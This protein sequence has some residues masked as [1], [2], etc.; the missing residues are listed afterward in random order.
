MWTG[1]AIFSSNAPSHE[2][3]EAGVFLVSRVKPK[4][5]LFVTHALESVYGAATS[6]RL[7]LENYSGV[8]ADLLLPRSFR[9]PRDLDTTA[10]RFPVVRRAYEISMPVDLGLLG[11]RRGWADM[12][13]GAAHWLG[14]QRDRAAY[15]QILRDGN[16]DIVH[17]NSP[18]LH[19]MVP[20]G[21]LA[22]THMR[23][24]I[25]DPG[26]PVIDRL[27]N[28]RGII[29]IDTTTRQPF[30]RREGSMHAVTLNNPIDMRDVVTARALQHPRLKPGTTVFSMIGRISELKGV[31]LVIEAFR[32]GAGADAALL[33]VGSGPESYVAHCR[34]LAADDPR[35]LFWGEEQNIKCVYAAT[36]YVVRGDPQPC[37][38]RTVYEGLYA[39]CRVLMPGPG[40]ADMI[41]EAE[42]FQDA[43]VFYAPR[44]TGA[45]AATFAAQHGLKAQNRK[46]RSNV[47][48]YIEAFDRFADDCIA[49]GK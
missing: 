26:S 11:I 24:I 40:A 25:I 45:L 33:I 19:H 48:S 12:A 30:A 37:V 2:A 14:W 6:L 20:P 16:Y 15:R 23:D 49:G 9:H 32:Q 44:N 3:P 31:S 21:L 38:G 7:L 36:D 22:V 17:F 18:V 35:I 1:F 29:F 34:A 13:H 4:R 10:A 27:A 46:Y 8:E 5:I 41:F 42:K 28:G 47:D 39:G 43:I